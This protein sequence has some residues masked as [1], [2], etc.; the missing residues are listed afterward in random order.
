MK[1][2]K[3]FVPDLAGLISSSPG[4]GLI[5]PGQ[6]LHQLLSYVRFNEFMPGNI[7]AY[8]ADRVDSENPYVI[9]QGIPNDSLR[10]IQSPGGFT[11]GLSGS[12]A[13]GPWDTKAGNISTPGVKHWVYGGPAFTHVNVAGTNTKVE[14][15]Y[16]QKVLSLGYPHLPPRTFAFK[17]NANQLSLGTNDRL[18]IM[19]RVM[20]DPSRDGSASENKAILSFGGWDASGTPAITNYQLSAN[21]YGGSSTLRSTVQAASG[22]TDVTENLAMTP[23]VWSTVFIV[24][25]AWNTEGVVNKLRCYKIADDAR[26]LATAGTTTGNLSG[27]LQGVSDPALFVGYGELS[28]GVNAD[29]RTSDFVKGVHIAELA[30]FKG[31]L[32]VEMQD[33]IAR[34]HLPRNQRKSGIASRPVRKVQ[35]LFDSMTSYPTNRQMDGKLRGRTTQFA[36]D[37]TKEKVFGSADGSAKHH[38]MMVYPEAFPARLYSGSGGTWYCG[39]YFP[40]ASTGSAHRHPGAPLVR[41]P[42][43]D[44]QFRDLRG[45]PFQDKLV[46]S[47]AVRPG[48]VHRET[49]IFGRINAAG[50][51]P[52]QALSSSYYQ[53]LGG[54]IS[55]F[56][57][58][59]A[60][61]AWVINERAVPPAI[62]P[63]F[64]QKLGDVITIEIPIPTN[65]GCIMGVDHTQGR[66]ASMAYYN[67][68]NAK[69]DRIGFMPGISGSNVLD[70]FQLDGAVAGF[71]YWEDCRNFLVNSCSIGFSGTSGFSIFEDEAN[72]AL[73]EL[74]IRGRPTSMYGFPHT[75]QYVAG[76][77]QTL[78]ISDYI[79]QPFLLEKIAIE[80][81][82]EVEEAGPS[83][84]ATTIRTP[85]RWRGMADKWTHAGGVV[86]APAGTGGVRYFYSC[87]RSE[88]QPAGSDAWR[89]DDMQR[90]GVH[91]TVGAF[92][93]DN[94]KKATQILSMGTPSPWPTYVGG[95]SKSLAVF[96]QDLAAENLAVPPSYDR[97]YAVQNMANDPATI[98]GRDLQTTTGTTKNPNWSTT[99]VGYHESMGSACN[100]YSVP[101]GLFIP[102]LEPAVEDG[103]TGGRG[104]RVKWGGK[105]KLL[106]GGISGLVTGSDPAGASWVGDNKMDREYLGFTDAFS[107]DADGNMTST[108]MVNAQ[109]GTVGAFGGERVTG[110]APFWRCD[111]FFL[112]RQRPGKERFVGGKAA[113]QTTKGIESF[114]KLLPKTGFNEGANNL[115]TQDS[116][117]YLLAQ[118]LYSS[119][120]PP[121]AGQGVGS[122]I[123]A[124]E[125]RIQETLDEFANS[126]RTTSRELVT[127][128]Q[129]THHGY[130]AAE[131]SLESHVI[132]PEDYY[133]DAD[134]IP[135]SRMLKQGV[136]GYDGLGNQLLVGTRSFYTQAVKLGAQSTFDTPPAGNS[137]YVNQAGPLA[138]T[139]WSQ[140]GINS[141]EGHTQ[142]LHG[143]T[144]AD[145]QTT[146][147]A[148]TQGV[149]TTA[150]PGAGSGNGLFWRFSEYDVM[151]SSDPAGYGNGQDHRITM[152]RF[153]L[154][155]WNQNSV[156]GGS[157]YVNDLEFDKWCVPIAHTGSIDLEAGG[158]TLMAGGAL[159]YMQIDWRYQCGTHYNSGVDS[160]PIGN[161]PGPRERG[162]GEP[163]H[164]WW[165]VGGRATRTQADVDAI[166]SWAISTS[167]HKVTGSMFIGSMINSASQPWHGTAITRTGTSIIT[168][169]T[170]PVPAGNHRDYA[171]FGTFEKGGVL[172]SQGG[173]GGY[174]AISTPQTYGREDRYMSGA[175]APIKLQNWLASGLGRDLNI[176][177]KH[178]FRHR[179]T[180]VG[181]GVA[182][183]TILTASTVFPPGDFSGRFNGDHKLRATFYEQRL[184]NAGNFRVVA[185]IKSNPATTADTAHLFCFTCPT[186]K[187][188]AMGVAS[189]GGVNTR[190]SNTRLWW[191]AQPLE[192][193]WIGDTTAKE[194]TWGIGDPP[195]L[196]S[197]RRFIA[198]VGGDR[199]A[200]KGG[201]SGSIPQISAGPGPWKSFFGGQG[202]D[203]CRD[204]L[205]A[206]TGGADQKTKTSGFAQNLSSSFGTLPE[207]TS[208][209]VLM[210]GDELVLGFQPSLHGSNRGINTIPTNVN[211]NPYGPWRDG[212]YDRQEIPTGSSYNPEFDYA[213]PGWRDEKKDSRGQ[214]GYALRRGPN[215]VSG[216]GGNIRTINQVNLESLYE[217]RS[218]FKITANRHAK[219][220]LYGTLLKNNKPVT[221]TLSQRQGTNAVHEAIYGAPVV[222]QFQTFSRHAYTGSYNAHHITGSILSIQRNAVDMGLSGVIQ[223]K[224]R[225]FGGPYSWL[226]EYE[227]RVFRPNLKEIQYGAANALR[228]RGHVTSTGFDMSISGSFQRFVR[229]VDRSEVFYDSLP[230]NPAAIF[231]LDTALSGGL[232]AMAQTTT[233]KV[234]VIRLN[235]GQTYVDCDDSDGVPAQNKN[236]G[237]PNR[238]A[239]SA[240]P[241]ENRY[242]GVRRMIQP[243]YA[244]PGF[245]TTGS[246]V[247][248]FIIGQTRWSVQVASDGDPDVGA[249][250]VIPPPGRN[251]ATWPQGT[252][253]HCWGFRPVQVISIR[254]ADLAS[255][256]NFEYYDTP[257]GLQTTP[258]GTK[259]PSAA[260]IATALYCGW[261]RSPFGNRPIRSFGRRGY[262]N[263]I[264]DTG[265]ENAGQ[266]D[267]P[268]GWKYGLMN[269]RRTSTAAVFRH[270]RYGQFRDMLEQRKYGRFYEYGD[271]LNPPGLQEAAV[272][273][274]FLDGDGSPVDDPHYTTCQNLSNEMTS[275]I[276]YKEGESARLLFTNQLVTISPLSPSFSTGGSRF[277]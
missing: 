241:F 215:I 40:Y 25:E 211:V 49:E 141:D 185:P 204:Y 276:P 194:Y 207:Q 219:L 264:N 273:C 97:R 62:L 113:I 122:I 271:E 58:N 223:R 176:N 169:P 19:L 79:D 11:Y 69:W 24:L 27:N 171:Q 154:N 151:E 23:G 226:G 196:S 129:I 153:R 16:V 96:M 205:I 210:P 137:V 187:P 139:S 50:Y 29:Y 209:Y 94:D 148:T 45:T 32:S 30:V 178:N 261:W 221:P 228:H 54:H 73:A 91:A 82:A 161:A 145:G 34:A 252:G 190:F 104:D 181:M 87:I 37:A 189:A 203:L 89:W 186:K 4:K 258:Y 42:L 157:N 12:W 250:T 163:I 53:A 81:S 174:T 202:V 260:N 130:A 197:G 41:I 162:V 254:I 167:Q 18:T 35:Q 193:G 183:F 206:N 229:L 140:E 184:L 262:P 64:D 65:E 173:I 231:E 6:G 90:V 125:I 253:Q 51:T 43:K 230:P 118:K 26:L 105:L 83:S 199:P 266:L 188:L 159:N 166:P 155:Q 17:K 56:N 220:V 85:H 200:F 234:S 251:E 10:T 5:S 143:V 121:D 235:F 38:Q 265:S 268:S 127:Y 192:D 107:I 247:Q 274:I 36:Y 272:T 146:V 3:I 158:T 2:N 198:A 277:I 257:L 33:A 70:E 175:F 152:Q 134:N 242:R 179:R 239:L 80:F 164:Q 31:S 115:T 259:D 165:N 245:S 133:D 135:A 240:F 28:G 84:I 156:Y 275:S 108:A 78:K 123:N 120:T 124:K 191:R 103:G 71:S 57:D 119:D 15:L 52:N 227:R 243:A 144:T 44:G 46:T 218:S 76:Q 114:E 142:Y 138:R 201:S 170:T 102:Q 68:S 92:G 59:Q 267:H 147:K 224:G 47:G 249:P 149:L 232:T 225:T 95:S 208:L 177:V 67:F 7:S 86:R 48:V 88:H 255:D 39:S 180:D 22:G 136:A 217:P 246:I 237:R 109:N 106:F 256:R 75:D 111:T 263:Y 61:D 74:P 238:Y 195:Q 112:L 101:A 216:S 222:D 63:G 60:G 132:L 233:S 98:S 248:A 128:A 269:F 93:S 160:A 214:S 8:I 1:V 9:S 244:N 150:D 99:V 14:A 116:Q 236:P 66:I 126:T 213:R 168:S 100:Y 117:S 212:V 21:G 77:G 20:L 182:G 72:L 131:S 13:G 55:P 270:D 172:T 110:G